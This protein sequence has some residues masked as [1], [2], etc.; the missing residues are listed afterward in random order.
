MLYLRNGM[1]LAISRR[2]LAEGGEWL[3][4]ALLDNVTIFLYSKRMLEGVSSVYYLP[5]VLL[6]LI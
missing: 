3:F 4:C 5:M 2:P 6:E 1:A